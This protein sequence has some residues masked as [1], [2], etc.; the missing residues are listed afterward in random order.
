MP[1]LDQFDSIEQCSPTHNWVLL[2]H[3]IQDVTL[4][5]LARKLA[6]DIVRHFCRRCE[7]HFQAW[8]DKAEKN[9]ELPESS[10]A[11]LDAFL[12][13]VFGEPGIPFTKGKIAHLEGFIGE[14][15]WYFLTLESNDHEIA[16]LI[17]PGFKVTDPGVDGFIIYRFPDNFL[18]FR[19]WEIKKFSP[20]IKDSS[21]RIEGTFDRAYS[22]LDAKAMEFLARI[23]VTEQEV[24]NQELQ[25]F[26]GRLPDLW[27][28]ASSQAGAGISVVTSTDH[29][30][31]DCFDDFGNRF[32][33]FTDPV[34]LQGMLTGVL[35][36]SKFS[37]LVQEYIWKGL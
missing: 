10:V 19:I 36:F 25:E 27:Q 6:T 24:H 23:T 7:H 26:M 4:E 31:M 29:I 1:I 9:I 16:Y 17:P 14:W 32:P 13:P 35:D 8:F 28:D 2:S 12:K 37:S 3:R 21:Q 5:D 11:A 20:S 30:K 22:Q 18:M 33:K 15:L 34:Q